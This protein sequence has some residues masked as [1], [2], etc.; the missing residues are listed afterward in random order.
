MEIATKV[1]YI[2]PCRS[3]LIVNV[4]DLDRIK[5]D[6]SS[7]AKR[8]QFREYLIEWCRRLIAFSLKRPIGKDKAA[9]DLEET[10]TSNKRKHSKRFTK[11]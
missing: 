2:V 1:G 11:C 10:N 8:N 7:A 5:S 6:Q 4:T 9:V 3:T